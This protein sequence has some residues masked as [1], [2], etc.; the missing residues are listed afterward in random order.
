MEKMSNTTPVADST[1]VVK[2]GATLRERRVAM[3]LSVADVAAQIRLAP[4]Q[5]EALESDDFGHLPELPFVRG[6]VRSYAKLL[7][8]DEQPLLATLPDPHLAHE[9]IEPVSVDVPF[10]IKQLSKQ[11][12]QIWLI[13]SSVVAVIAL[14]F[15]WWHFTTPKK[16]SVGQAETA[17][18]MEM[19]VVL[20]EQTP[21]MSAVVQ[22]D[23]AD[24][25]PD[26][27]QAGPSAA[28]AGIPA[29]KSAS[30]LVQ[31]TVPAPDVSA[32]PATTSTKLRIV[33]DGES[34]S[35]IKDATGKILSSQINAPGSELNLN[36]RA[37][38]DLV[39]GNARTV[40]LYRRG[41][42]VDLTRYINKTSEVA[43]L[44]LE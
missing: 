6:F 25:R 18:V 17:K 10:N 11:Q 28:P 14:A 31:S 23:G 4:R 22:A 39:I 16:I 15:A 12:N 20:P 8:L 9:R 26:E 33:F 42:P 38:Y 2:L 5:I 21:A 40:H 36:G 13:A 44:T 3:G 7:Q 30:T 27:V 24:V 37:P 29:L 19:A 34:W 32:P 35:E 43:R 1:P 41:K